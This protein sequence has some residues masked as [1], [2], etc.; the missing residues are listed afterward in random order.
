MKMRKLRSGLWRRE[1]IALAAS[2][3][4]SML[5]LTLVPSMTV[6]AQTAGREG[7]ASKPKSARKKATAAGAGSA[8]A[9]AIEKR[10]NALLARMTL[11]E[12]VGQLNQM[13]PDNTTAEMVRKGEVGSILDLTDP[14]RIHAMQQVAV[15]QSRLHI[16][17]LFG[18]DVIHGYRTIFP[19][20]LAMAGSFDPS[21][22]ETA[23][24]IAAAEA[25]ACGERWTFAP[26]LDIA[27]DSRWGRIT[28]GNG[29]DP[30]L[31]AAMAGAAVRGFQ[32][33]DLADPHHLLACAK[34]Y[35]AYGA[36]E[37]GRD[38]NTADMSEATL[39]NIYLPPFQAAVQA[40]AQSFMTAFNDLNGTP[41]V[42]NR[43]LLQTVLRGE[44]KYT[45]LVVS[46]W[47]AVNELIHHGVAADDAQAT[48]KALTAGTDMDMHD[49]AYRRTLAQLVRS[50]RVPMAAVNDAVRNVLRVKFELGLFEHPY[51]GSAAE[52]RATWLTPQNRAAAR[53]A[54]EKS[55]ILLRNEGGTL[56][57]ASDVKRVAV[58]GPLA[59]D[60]SE[61]LS[62]WYGIGRAEDTV[63]LLQALKEKLPQ[64]EIRY[65]KGVE[66]HNY[67]LAA[68]DS[69][70]PADAGGGAGSDEAGI[71][72]AVAAAKGADVAILALGETAEMSGEGG[73][74]SS[75]DLPGA[76]EQLLEAVAA[77]GTPVV[78]VLMNGHPLSIRWAA[79]HVPAILEMWEAG[80]E[81][82]HAAVDLLFG[83]A[84][85]GAKLPVS[86][87]RS[88]DQI[89]IYYDHL[90]TGRPPGAT[91]FTSRYQD[92]PPTPLFPFG[93]GLSYTTFRIS[94][95]HLASGQIP[96]SGTLQAT[97]MVTNTGSRAGD[98]VA[99]LY[100]HQ[101]VATL[102]QPVRE[103]KA[104]QRVTLRPGES[105]EL[106][107][108]VPA[109]NL[110]YWDNQGRYRLEPGEFDVYV[111]D[112]SVG[113]LQ[114]GFEL[115]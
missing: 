94:D 11:E 103:L 23:D 10:V 17:I 109:R 27:R 89:P 20:P 13:L 93:F 78:L 104:F 33:G 19:I 44:W 8:A 3:G 113:G 86:V 4:F 38:Y 25:T 58:I 36:A 110:G 88:A 106:H 82:G 75:L 61:P 105:R 71:Q 55:A 84:N 74:R 92:L 95:L 16:P 28:E 21:V 76:Q 53:Q 39:R 85:P 100:I 90:N 12:K 73:S 96:R 1:Y 63:T 99:Q 114:T 54:A 31:G 62:H 40:G 79:A 49:G 32:G 98:E 22:V 18:F 26:M 91:R 65:E 111:G 15:E 34:H 47:D 70:A 42:E 72:R 67:N 29:E 112:S 50:G 97:V 30:V 101:R 43:F 14:D 77:T 46:D 102:S 115:E 64:A 48:L 7:I 35:A 41:G 69:G 87:P 2:V 52:A 57:L 56:P 59:D 37:G 68:V 60:G 45:G 5:A 6:V 66:L 108:S 81:A 51:N 83:D 80:T 9:A 107:F 24:R